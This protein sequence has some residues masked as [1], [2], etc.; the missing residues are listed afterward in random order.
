M[1]VSKI[2]GN[3][4]L[5]ADY[6]IWGLVFGCVGDV[7]LHSLSGKMWHFAIGVVS[8]L[9]GHI[10]Y[11]IAIQKA[12]FA[13]YPAS[14]AIEWYEIAP[15]ALFIAVACFICRKQFKKQPA[16]VA[17]LAVYGTVLVLM[18][19]KA[20]RYAVGEIAYGTNDNMLA[21]SLTIGLGA[22]LFVVS[23]LI[24][25]VILSKNGETKRITRIVNI[26]T[27]YLC[28]LYTSPSPRD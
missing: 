2:S 27:Y 7:M 9:V 21:L 15:V 3:N 4:T 17:G 13:T 8:F 22:I 23:D 19:V 26:V 10:F 6:I 1:L 16:I 14:N 18:L 20:V 25:G 5:Y 12:I 24:L 28:L 11:I